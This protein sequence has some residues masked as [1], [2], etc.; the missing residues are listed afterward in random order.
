MYGIAYLTC[1]LT[2]PEQKHAGLQLREKTKGKAERAVNTKPNK[3]F[4]AFLMKSH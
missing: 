2:H 3:L 4:I 1:A